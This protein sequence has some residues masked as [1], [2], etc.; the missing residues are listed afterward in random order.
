MKRSQENVPLRMRRRKLG[1][2][3]PMLIPADRLA[4][5]QLSSIAFDA[6]VDVTIRCRR[7]NPHNAK[8]WALLHEVVKASEKYATAEHLHRALLLALGYTDNLITLDGR[9]LVIPDSTAF[10]K[11]DQK[12]FEEYYT[13]A[14]ALL[15]TLLG[16][17][18]MT[19]LKNADAA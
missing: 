15:A 9:T 12:K 3:H 8:Y 2:E 1:R 14:V 18:P 4:W 13:K 19:L 7:S 6:E 17:D 16:D 11:M 10:G 5:Q